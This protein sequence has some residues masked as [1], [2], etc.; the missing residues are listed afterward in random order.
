M[1]DNVGVCQ[2]GIE[3]EFLDSVLTDRGIIEESIGINQFLR[4]KD[5]TYLSEKKLIIFDCD[6]FEHLLN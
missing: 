3:F 5:V 6:V 4:I 1:Y 2:V